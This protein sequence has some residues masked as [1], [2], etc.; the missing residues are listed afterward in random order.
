MMLSSLLLIS[1]VVVGLYLLGYLIA[2]KRKKVKYKEDPYAAGIDLPIIRQ[3]YESK[4]VLFA[5]LFLVFD[6][7]AFM[8]VISEGIFYPVL[9]LAIVLLGMILVGSSVV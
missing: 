8:F 4:I 6:I 3:K 5:L 9:Y 1:L 2:P 7:L